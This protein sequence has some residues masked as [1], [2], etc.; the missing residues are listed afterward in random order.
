MILLL[1]LNGHF[2]TPEAYSEP[3]QKSKMERFAKIVIGFQPLIIFEMRDV[4][5][6][7]EYISLLGTLLKTD[8]SNNKYID[9][10]WNT[11]WKLNVKIEHEKEW[12]LNCNIL[13]LY[14]A[15]S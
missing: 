9:V 15:M 13:T 2:L 11:C 7:S 5:Q 6:Y 12:N 1:I 8:T 4:W 14:F 3:C 10:L